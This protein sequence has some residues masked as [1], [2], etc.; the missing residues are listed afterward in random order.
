MGL[1]QW[2]V[3]TNRISQIGKPW[4][5]SYLPCHPL[6]GC[7]PG[8]EEGEEEADE[9]E[10]I[11]TAQ[12]YIKQNPGWKKKKPKNLMRHRVLSHLVMSDS[13]PPRGP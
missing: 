4:Q 3:S 5:A 2:N 8:W 1:S 12:L 13:L 7:G 10:G 9:G 6:E 11:D